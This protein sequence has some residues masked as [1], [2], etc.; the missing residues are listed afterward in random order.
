MSKLLHPIADAGCKDRD[1]AGKGTGYHSKVVNHTCRKSS[2]SIM[3]WFLWCNIYM[4]WTWKD[5]V[6]CS[7]IQ[8]LILHLPSCSPFGDLNRPLLISSFEFG[9]I[10]HAKFSAPCTTNKTKM[11]TSNGP[12]ACTMFRC[13]QC[14]FFY[15]SDNLFLFWK[16]FVGV[17]F[18]L[19]VWNVTVIPSEVFRKFFEQPQI[20][21]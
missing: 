17:H 19:Q 5:T 14:S 7:N 8:L 12:Y 13:W 4:E 6:T 16:I 2:N 10:Q 15:K 1:G 18:A 11:C 20:C 21:M 9:N 3:F